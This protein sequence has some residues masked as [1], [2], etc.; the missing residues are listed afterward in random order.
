[1]EETDAGNHDE[2]HSNIAATNPM[3]ASWQILNKWK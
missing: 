2:I 3:F 1:M